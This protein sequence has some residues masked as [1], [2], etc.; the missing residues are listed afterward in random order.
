M[1]EIAT[2][3]EVGE[4]LGFV[5]SQDTIDKFWNAISEAY[6]DYTSDAPQNS[7][8]SNLKKLNDAY[9][10]LVSHVT[11]PQPNKWYNIV[12]ITSRAFGAEQPVFLASTSVGDNMHI[13]TYMKDMYSYA[14]D[15]Y[16]IWRFVPAKE[17]EGAYYIQS[18]GTVQYLG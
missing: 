16:A 13:G 15:P 9:D 14:S 11:M 5:D 12:S 1:D 6:N 4:G 17:E 8:A 10:E 2:N 7:P 18:M 3:A